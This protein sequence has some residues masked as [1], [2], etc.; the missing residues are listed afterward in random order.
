[1][2]KVNLALLLVTVLMQSGCGGD[3]GAKL[4]ASGGAGA[5]YGTKTPYVPQQDAASYEAAPAGY[6]PVHTQLVARHAS[7]GLA[8]PKYDLAMYAIWRKAAED[9]ALTPLGERLG[10][11]ILKLMRTNAL[12]GVGVPDIGRP[13]YGNLSRL[14]IAEQQELAARMLRRMKSHFDLVGA[15]AETVPRRI[16]L[17]SS[18]VDRAEDSGLFFTRSLTSGSAALASLVFRPP[19]PSGY[20]A[21]APVARPDGSNRFLLYFFALKPEGEKVD[22]PAD[23]YYRTYLDS[24]DYQAFLESPAYLAAIGKLE[25][26]PQTKSI[27]RAIMERLFSKAFVD[28]ID[29]GRYRFTNAGSYTFTSDDGSFTNTIT[30]DGRT[31][32]GSLSDVVDMLYNLYV[33]APGLSREA[34]LDFAPYFLP[35]ELEA[36]SSLSDAHDFITKGPSIPASRG[37]TYRMAQV[38]LDDFFN[39]VDAIARGDMRTAANLRFGHAET[40]MPL[41]TLLGLKDLIVPLPASQAFSYDNNPWR[42]AVLT[43]VAA[44]MQWDTYRNAEGDILVKMLFN[45]RE[46]LFKAACDAARLGPDSHFYRYDGLKACY[47]HV[48]RQ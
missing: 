19:A 40:T 32:V 36:L 43:P 27:E 17:V 42:G 38:L 26:N 24:L 6:A 5:Y 16:V 13:G 20:P 7:R 1:M 25:D 11:D 28:K 44:N 10:A 41:A 4:P 35:E 34:A 30:G 3:S 46:R 8:T 33:I 39:E 48:A 45:E 14:G 22:A 31:G 23:P 18:G 21:L 47:G 29:D 12:L 15:T 9:A 2:K 37:A